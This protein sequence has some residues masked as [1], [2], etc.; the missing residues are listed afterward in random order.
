MATFSGEGINHL[1]V[2]VSPDI[3]ICGFCKQQ[4]NNFEHFFAHK[5]NC[6]QIPSTHISSR[7]A[8]PSESFQTCVP[9]VKKTL[10][11]AQKAPSKKL[12]PALSQKRHTC[13]F[14]GCT[15]KTQYGQKDME[16][17]ILTHTGKSFHGIISNFIIT[18]RC[19]MHIKMLRSDSSLQVRG[20]SSV[21][22]AINALVVAIS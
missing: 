16:R 19:Q 18:K 4:Y 20:L 13:T 9:K 10:T 15:F 14:S 3:H 7:N 2:E 11:K 1:L 6:C 21:N 8:G 12:K 17:H 22:S 5:Q